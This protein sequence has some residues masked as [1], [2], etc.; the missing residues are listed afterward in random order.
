MSL[1]TEPNSQNKT[2]AHNDLTQQNV[3]LQSSLIKSLICDFFEQSNL[4]H[5]FGMSGANI[6][7]LFYE[8]SKRNRTQIILAKNEYNAAMMAM[9][10]YLSNKRI[11]AALTTSGAGLMNALPVL[12]EA[13]SSE[14]PFVLI[15]GLIPEELHGLGGFQDTSGKSNTI[16]HMEMFKPCTVFCQTVKNAK[17]VLENLTKAFEAAQKY[18]RPAA[19]FIPKNIFNQS[20]HLPSTN[21]LSKQPPLLLN[22]HTDTSR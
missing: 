5:V 17:D 18:K 4:T 7:D 22:T 12:A 3:Q 14:V 11:T 8:L 16:Q 10:S 15:S 21:L 2:T 6:E 20:V 13:Y 9:G 19:L 1:T